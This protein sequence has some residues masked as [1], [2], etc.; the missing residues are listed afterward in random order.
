MRI[1]VA[2]KYPPC[3]TILWAMYIIIAASSLSVRFILSCNQK[4]V[5]EL[6]SGKDDGYVGLPHA[7]FTEPCVALDAVGSAAINNAIIKRPF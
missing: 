2:Q 3:S 1:C 6:V 4:S 7:D 5:L